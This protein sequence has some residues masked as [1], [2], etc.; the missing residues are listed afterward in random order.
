MLGPGGCFTAVRDSWLK[1]GI[2]NC[3]G[4]KELHG[5]N[6]FTCT[7]PFAPPQQQQYN[8]I[9]NKPKKYQQGDTICDVEKRS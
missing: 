9:N 4:D 3:C 8:Q 2:W 7:I 5:Q 1:C 6:I